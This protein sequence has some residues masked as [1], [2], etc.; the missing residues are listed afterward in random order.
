MAARSNALAAFFAKGMNEGSS[1]AAGTAGVM[2][3]L[4]AALLLAACGTTPV[5]APAG[6][7]GQVVPVEGDGQ[8]LDILPQ[9]LNAMLESKDFFFVNVHVPY[10]GEI[11][12]T[13]AFIPFDQTAARLG[14]YPQDRGAKI[15]L[16]C[17][18]GSMSAIAARDMVSA[19][20]TDIY[21]LDGGFRAWE[22]A[23]YELI[24]SP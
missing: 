10:E 17:R 20:Y 1:R 3:F 23:G 24:Q 12:Q 13:D 14:E 11:E 2:A 9:E 4:T 21:N 22:A 7:V 18:S 5:P 6:E 8:Y 16:Y 15:V 19:G